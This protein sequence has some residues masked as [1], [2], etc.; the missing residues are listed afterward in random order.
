MSEA[1][2]SVHAG[3]KPSPSCVALPRGLDRALLTTQRFR[4]RTANC[5]D[6]A[7]LFD[8]TDQILV[9]EL[10]R[11][12]NFG[13]NSLRDLLFVVEN[14]LQKLADHVDPPKL[15]PAYPSSHE[16]DQWMSIKD[17]LSELI[18]AASELH[19]A[20]SIADLLAPDIVKLAIMINVHGQ[21]QKVDIDSLSVDYTRLSA[22]VLNNAQH[23]YSTLTPN[24]RTVLDRRIMTSRP[25]SMASIGSL[26]GV[27]RARVQ[28][29]HAMLLRR[30]KTLFGAELRAVSQVLKAQL[31]PVARERAVNSRIDNL[32]TNDGT[33]GAALARH[34]LKSSLQYSRIVNG[35]CLDQSAS[36]I[37]EQ[38]RQ[39]APD[40]SEDGIIDLA[41][42][43]SA[44]PAQ[45]WERHW[46]LLLR[47]C[48]FRDVAGFLALRDSEKVRAKA[49]LLS[50]GTPATAEEIGEICGLSPARIRAYLPGFSNVVR[51]D[52]RRWGLSE[53]IDDEYEG[54]EA[55]IIQRIEEGGGVTTTDRLLRELPEKF[56]VSI[57]SVSACLQMP[58]FLLHDNGH[59][60]FADR[61]SGMATTDVRL[62]RLA[63]EWKV[64]AKLRCA[65]I[66]GFNL[67]PRITSGL[68]QVR[69]TSLLDLYF[70]LEHTIEA[71]QLSE[72]IK[73]NYDRHVVQNA[74]TKFHEALLK[75][76]RDGRLTSDSIEWIVPR[77]YT[78]DR[79]QIET[80]DAAAI[81]EILEQSFGARTYSDS[82]AR[83]IY[84]WLLW[85]P[86][87][88]VQH[89]R[90]WRASR[91]NSLHRALF[92]LASDTD[93]T[94]NAH[95]PWESDL[96]PE[97]RFIPIQVLYQY[98]PS[99]LT[100]GTINTLHD[101]GLTSINDLRCLHPNAVTAAKNSDQPLL[102]LYRRF[103]TTD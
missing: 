89:L 99:S 83:D 53:W 10:L 68:L 32:I 30:I 91:I 8:G 48:E 4:V 25:D 36:V 26:L 34:V 71:G 63:S 50:I 69:H 40:F 19:G 11:L 79:R 20:T 90:V 66:C 70:H 12:R 58:K 77:N 57:S 64:Q 73:T 35:I 88:V 38:L 5:L 46:A 43:R 84:E 49:A 61:S 74:Y 65:S 7:G 18:V 87:A 21:L 59:V 80:S 44:L 51:A 82:I 52:K 3:R 42:L 31:G 60:T 92:K 2:A 67:M 47:C 56:E 101:C 96:S 85:M 81:A 94:A 1:L 16:T 75:S 6:K 76:Y 13:L 78:T 98:E 86:L 23:L 22:V 100:L 45:E 102:R 29:I 93:K 95:Y 62:P 14:Y 27:S 54:I 103:N 17:P 28:Q 37:V 24:H 97:T 39:H 55:E 33:P 72:I 15:S 9:G 41:S